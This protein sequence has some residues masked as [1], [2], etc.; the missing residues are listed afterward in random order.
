[1]CGGGGSGGGSPS[2]TTTKVD[3]IVAPIEADES[4]QSAS[5]AE[6]KLRQ[7]YV[8]CEIL[9]SRCFPVRNRGAMRGNDASYEEVMDLIASSGESGARTGR[10]G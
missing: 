10:S 8:G 4:S 7:I 9:E 6:R 3:P 2:V 5:D 1:M